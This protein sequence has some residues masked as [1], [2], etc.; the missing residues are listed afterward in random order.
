[1]AKL[2]E[3]TEGFPGASGLLEAKPSEAQVGSLR[4]RPWVWR[5]QLLAPGAVLFQFHYQEPF[6]VLGARARRHCQAFRVP[7][8]PKTAAPAREGASAP[9]PVQG[10]SASA[11]AREPGASSPGRKAQLQPGCS[12]FRRLGLSRSRAPSHRHLVQPSP[13]PMAGPERHAFRFVADLGLSS[14]LPRQKFRRAS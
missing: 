5:E 11:R 7:Y 6:P 1:M 14:Q 12:R 2:L 4:D 10:W 13:G 9:G 8:P 3:A